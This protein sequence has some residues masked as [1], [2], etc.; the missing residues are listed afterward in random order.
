MTILNKNIW[1]AV[2]IFTTA[3]I[4][5]AN[6]A[7]ILTPSY[8]ISDAAANSLLILDAKSFHLWVGHYS[9]VGFNHPGP[10]ILYVLT[11]GEA[12]FYNALHLVKTPISGQFIA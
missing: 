12:L 4:I 1:I 7:L 10:A 11:G 8:E 2:F 6:R 3:L 9:R 5:F